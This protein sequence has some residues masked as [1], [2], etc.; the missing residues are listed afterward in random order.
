MHIPKNYFSEYFKESVKHIGKSKPIFFILTSIELIE[1]ATNLIDKITVLFRQGQTFNHRENK[2]SNIVLTISPYHH[3]FTYM[4]DHSSGS[5]STNRIVLIIIVILYLI[6][7]IF[8]LKMNNKSDDDEIEENKYFLW[9]KILLVNFFDYFLFRLLPFYT[10]DV[11]IREIIM[12]ASKKNQTVIDI[13]LLFIFMSFLLSVSFLHILYY[14]Q[15]CSWSNFKVIN[16]YLKYYPYDQFFSSKFETTNYFLKVLITLNQ[17]YMLFHDSYI[18]FKAL[19]TSF[20]ILCVFLAFFLYT[21]SIILFSS[22]IMFFYLSFFNKLRVFYIL[23]FFES[24]VCRIILNKNEDFIPFLL[25][26]AILII[27]NCYLVVEGFEPFVL[28]RVINNQNYLGVCWFIQGNDI[29][30]QHFTAEWI[31]YHKTECKD[32]Y[33]LICK[34]MGDE[35]RDYF[36][37]YC[38]NE[39]K[40]FIS[41][42]ILRQNSL[43]NKKFERK[44]QINSNKNLINQIFPPFK[45]S[46]AL[47][48][49]AERTK[50]FMG[51]NDLIRLDFLHIMVLFLSD[52]SIE[53]HLF[54][55]LCKLIIKYK[56]NTNVFVSLLL[57]FDII[58]KS[59][60]SMIK[61]YDVIKKNEDLRNSLNEYI[62]K[63]EN[64][65]K[66]GDKSP[67]NYISISHEFYKFKELVKDIHVLFKK[68]IECNYQLLLMRY[69]YENLLHLQF[70]NTVPFDL[71]YYS[72]FLDFHFANDKIILMK[73]FIEHDYFLIIK[74]SKELLKY[75][76]KQFSKIFPDD[77]ERIAINKFKA[78]LI[79]SEQKDIKPL[80]EFFVKSLNNNQSFGFIESFKMKYLIYPTNIINELYIQANYLSNYSTIMIFQIFDNEEFLYCFS[81]QLYKIIGLT[82]KMVDALI[83]SGIIISFNDLFSNKNVSK[84]EQDK[85]IYK[86][87]FE[88]YYP[89]YQFLLTNDS[90][91]DNANFSQMK[92]KINEISNMANEKKEILFLITKKLEINFTNYKYIIYTLKEQR[93]KKRGEKSMTRDNSALKLDNLSGSRS[94]ENS[95]E[96]NDGDDNEFDEHFEGKGIN[97]GAS[98]FSSASFS[99]SARSTGSSLAKG[100]KGAKADEKNKRA[101]ELKRYTVIIL[102]FGG[103]LIMITI[104]FLVLE[105]KQ[106]NNFQSLFNLFEAFRRFKR[107]VESSP[108]SL[109]TNYKYYIN[110]NQE[111]ENIYEI[112]SKEIYKFD[113]IFKDILLN[114]MI[115]KELKSK[116]GSVMNSFDNYKKYMFKLGSQVSG[117]ISALRG[118]SYSLVEEG[119]GLKFIKKETNLIDLIRQYN[120]II[121]SVLENDAYKEEYSLLS[122]GELVDN[123]RKIILQNQKTEINSNTKDML[124]LILMYP[125]IHDGLKE[126]S[127]LIE[128]LFDSSL[129]IIENYLII[130]YVILLVLHCVLLFICII[131]L[132]SYTKMMKINI[133]SSNQLFSDKKFLE[134]QNKRIEQIK[135]MNNLYSE[136]PLKIAEKIDLIDDVY[137]KKT[138]EDS[139]PVKNNLKVLAASESINVPDEKPATDLKSK[140][141]ENISISVSKSTQAKLKNNLAPNEDAFLKA[142]PIKT[143]NGM[144]S[145]NSLQD[146][147]NKVNAKKNANN[148]EE[149]I[150]NTNYDGI[151]SKNVKLSNKQFKKVINKEIYI[152]S[153]TFGFFYLFNIIFFIFVYKAKSQMNVLIDYCD[154]NNSID[155]YLFDN[156]NALIYLYV[157]NSTSVFYGQLIHEES[158]IDYIQDGINTLYDAVRKKDIIETEH[159]DLFPPLGD[160]INLNCNEYVLPDE[161]FEKALGD[162]E[163]YEKYYKAICQLLPVASSGS[164]TNIIMEILYSVEFMYQKFMPN[165]DFKEIYRLYVNQTKHYSIYTLVLTLSRII[166]TYYNEKIFSEEVNN[167][168]NSFSNIFIVYLVLSVIFE[169]VIFFVLNFGIISDV[170]KT[171]KL[172]LDFMSSLRF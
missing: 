110:D 122:F 8:F 65:I 23:L 155:G 95:Q 3:F 100:K 55:E 22:D 89:F 47:L 60:L 52:V 160:V 151:V 101:E 11:I 72:D 148:N 164:D 51:Q 84:Y 139:T 30:I 31:T 123:S 67:L 87:Q 126:T 125:F 88:R 137:R 91:K 80:F 25:Y 169:V 19:F 149:Q 144:K 27:L 105:T 58:R 140:N 28:A 94:D 2:L 156:V 166:R 113:P 59:N 33:C 90:L 115:I 36:E 26:E 134:M 6:F 172:L 116:F 163:T 158:N 165:E 171:N 157:T 18:D 145:L 9:L 114:T 96:E 74:S 93:R 141:S 127:H 132:L 124:L 4:K 70:K 43:T 68:N 50:K 170:R 98:T 42:N 62:K 77:F 5:F 104:L 147:T 162:Y 75:Q 86:F 41:K 168:F 13:L 131:F 154:I 73:Y 71:N 45:F 97:L 152:L 40:T 61:G 85:N 39:N 83:K 20:I 37:D 102:L 48:Q 38:V 121:V 16:S 107:G 92:D 49:M 46:Y 106:N 118:Y 53:F 64:F 143:L 54:N 14:N 161:Y 56:E 57:V 15:I 159:S 34:E 76:G 108:L 167:I 44:K 66:F 35:D 153:F 10:L 103:F 24:L 117:E 119:N 82:P 111:G 29:D 78:Q 128:K 150:S 138:R 136:H 63:Y 133:F 81:P 112:Y 1:L 12:I 129:S 21:F 17:N 109:L 146:P 120:N 99:G 142:D 32:I 69:A 130:F 135:I 79:N 7:M